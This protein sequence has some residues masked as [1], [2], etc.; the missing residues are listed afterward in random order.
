ME[1]REDEASSSKGG[2]EADTFER[3]A[4]FVLGDVWNR[5]E[6]ALRNAEGEAF[7]FDV[8]TEHAGI[9]VSL[10]SGSWVTISKQPDEHALRVS[11]TL[12]PAWANRGEAVFRLTA[13]APGVPGAPGKWWRWEECAGE[14]ECELYS[15]LEEGLEQSLKAPGS[16]DKADKTTPGKSSSRTITDTVLGEHEHTIVGYS[17]IKGIGDGEP[18]ASER[19]VVGGHEWVLLFYPDGKRSSSEAHNINP[20]QIP[21]PHAHLQQAAVAAAGAPA[22]LPGPLPPRPVGGGAGVPLAVP[23]APARPPPAALPPGALP[24]PGQPAAAAAAAAAAQQQQAV[25]AMQQAVA[26]MQQ[27]AAAMPLAVPAVV[28]P[29]PHNPGN[30]YCALFV[31]LI[32]ETDNPQGVVNTSEGRVVRAFHRF[33]LVDQSGRGQDITKGRR[34]DQGAVKISCARQDPNARNCHGYRKFVKKS[35]LEDPQRGL[36]VSDTIVIRYQIELVVSTGG[37]L[38]RAHAGKQA[39]QIALPP[40][41][42]GPELGTLLESGAGSDVTFRV[43]D[44]SM[45]AHKIILQARCACSPRAF[46]GWGAGGAPAVDP[47]PG[48][49]LGARR[50]RGPRGRQHARSPVF[51]AL[52]TGPMRE[53][54]GGPVGIQD[55]KPQVFRALLHFAYTDSLPE[56]L[57]ARG[58][59]PRGGR[60][61]AGRRRSGGSRGRQ[62][63]GAKGSKLEVPMAQHLLAAADR[64]Q[65]IRLRCI[66]E[67][68]L[69]ET[70]EVDTVATTLALAEQNNARELKR[71]CLEFVSKNLQ[72]VMDS[73][74]YKY[75]TDTCPQLQ[76]E[77]LQVIAS[78]PPARAGG[79]SVHIAHHTHARVADESSTDGQLRRVRPR[80]E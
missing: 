46:E 9:T 40:P 59:A 4:D 39:L 60:R 48:T 38:S 17:L 44:E 62:R 78:A 72:A 19:F 27:A 34:R 67:Q 63:D 24:A 11:N 61:L 32:G 26:A 57:Q 70:V 80:R 36:L 49:P 23:P 76:S 64:F 14:E 41:S 43:E 52:L 18:I 68:R 28:A 45:G 13:D 50:P 31:A 12:F 51:R 8:K 37:A 73:E 56:E 55:V 77:L 15:F 33:T 47:T 20:Q 29:P 21:Q 53:G 1:A 30:D 79:R 10:P 42:L 5:M 3:A 25:A 71:V 7:E 69:C 2:M 74:G 66:C 54:Q 6:R 65:L 75:M 35:V 58:V 16:G 22:V